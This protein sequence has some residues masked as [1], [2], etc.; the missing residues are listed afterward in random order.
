VKPGSPH[1]ELN[2]AVKEKITA[3]MGKRFELTSKALDLFR[4]HTDP[5]ERQW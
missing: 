3:T 2:F 1:V 4:F 5:G